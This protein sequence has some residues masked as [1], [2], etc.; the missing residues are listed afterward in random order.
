MVEGDPI[1]DMQEEER[2]MIE[3]EPPEPLVTECAFLVY[4]DPQ[5]HWVGD[6]DKVNNPVQVG[7]PAT[8]NDYRH[9]AATIHDDLLAADTASRAAQGTVVLQ[10]QLAMQMA[11][12]MEAAKL[13]QA[14]GGHT[15]VDLSELKAR[16]NLGGKRV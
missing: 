13:G 6:S 11:K 3:T 14:T 12:Q 15:G 5:G 1:K 16:A 8:L 4:L 7:R 2:H 9:A 10:Q